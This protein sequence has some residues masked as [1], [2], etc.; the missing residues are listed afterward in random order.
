MNHN[1]LTDESNN[2]QATYNAMYAA[3]D[4]VRK[5]EESHKELLEA[6]QLMVDTYDS[7]ERSDAT[8]YRCLLIARDAI[9]KAKGIK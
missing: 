3:I 8:I 7:G 9:A 5:L 6:L 4:D 2:L 1:N